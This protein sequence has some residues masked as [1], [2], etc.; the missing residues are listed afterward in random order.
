MRGRRRA[1]TSDLMIRS[2][3]LGTPSWI[4]LHPI[5]ASQGPDCRVYR[6]RED[7]SAGDANIE[8]RRLSISPNGIYGTSARAGHSALMLAARITLPHFS[9][10]SA[11]NL[12]KS[13]GVI[14]IGTEPS[15]AI[16]ALIA[17]SVRPALISL[18][19][20]STTSVGVSGRAHAMKGARLIAR[21]EI[22]NG[23]NIRQ[24]LGPCC[25][26]HGQSAQ[27]AGRDVPNGPR[28]SVE[29]D[30]HLSGKQID[31][32]GARAAIRHVHKVD[33][34]HHLE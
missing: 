34:R 24:R 20:L 9:V 23:W 21:H 29:H 4:E 15:S 7:Q 14:G 16:R 22:A 2:P 5:A 18:L 28:H 8:H 17:G 25:C 31:K 30:L 6:I 1:R 11:M 19:S 3:P 10:S 13:T 32:R 27:L 12:A 33:T 26:G